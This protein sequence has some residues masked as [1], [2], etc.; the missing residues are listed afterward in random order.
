MGCIAAFPREEDVRV[1]CGILRKNGFD[2]AGKALTGAAALNCAYGAAGGIL[3]CAC[4]FRDMNF[5]EIRQNLPDSFSMLLVCRSSLLS[6][7]LPDNVVFLPLPLKVN[8][9]VSTLRTLEAE[10][11]GCRRRKRSRPPV[12]TEAEEKLIR[13]A[14]N[15]LMDRNGMTEPEAHR[16]MQKYSMDHGLNLMETSETVLHY[17]SL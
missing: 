7:A 14:K 16:W 1:I 4:Q 3:I 9:F 8:A 6:E 11:S 10:Q 5:T 17:W 13:D 2:V 15:V 12:R